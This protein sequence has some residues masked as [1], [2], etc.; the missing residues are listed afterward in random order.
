MTI[1]GTSVTNAGTLEALAVSGGVA[2][3]DVSATTIGNTGV[4]KA[5][6]SSTGQASLELDGAVSN[7]KSALIVASATGSNSSAGV[8]GASFERRN[9]RQ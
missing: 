6:A 2:A 7:A 1:N 4:I 3:T 9:R 5:L 8:A